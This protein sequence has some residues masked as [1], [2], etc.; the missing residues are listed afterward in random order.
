MES[1]SMHRARR[2]KSSICTFEGTAFAPTA[3]A[4]CPCLTSYKS[5]RFADQLHILTSSCS[6]HLRKLLKLECLCMPEEETKVVLAILSLLKMSF[7]IY[8]MRYKL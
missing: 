1:L 4:L 2:F 5:T 3:Y 6:V 7:I 8:V